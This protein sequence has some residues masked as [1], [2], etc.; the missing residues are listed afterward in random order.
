MHEVEALAVERGAE[1]GQAAAPEEFTLR[2]VALERMAAHAAPGRGAGLHCAEGFQG[3][4]A[5]TARG[6]PPLT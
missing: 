1:V 2:Q 4:S 6:L 3:R 5:E